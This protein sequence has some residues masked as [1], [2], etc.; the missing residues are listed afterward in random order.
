MHLHELLPTYLGCAREVIDVSPAGAGLQR[1]L[2]LPDDLPYGRY[3]LVEAA[4]RDLGPVTLIVSVVGPDPAEHSDPQTVAPL[5]RQLEV[6][7]RLILLGGWPIEAL[8][9]HRLLG[10]LVDGNCQVIDAVPLEPATAPAGV[11]CALII[12]RVEKLAPVRSHLTDTSAESGQ[13]AQATAAAADELRTLLRVV[14]ECVLAE[15]VARPSQR[16]LLELEN[17]TAERDAQVQQL[18][19]LLASS[20]SRLAVLES[21]ITFQVGQAV[22]QAVRNPVRGVVTLP[23]EMAGAWRRRKSDRV[24]PI[25]LPETQPGAG[26]HGLLTMTAPRD[27][28]VPRMLA[29]EG[30]VGYEHE[31]LACFLAAMDIAG[32]GAV[33]DIGA[34]VGVYAAVASA[35]TKREVRAFEPSPSLVAAA[36]R[37]A[38]DNNLNFTTESLALGAEN[39]VATFYLSDK[40]DSSNSLAAGFRKSSMQIEVQVE[41]LDSYVARTGMVPA[42]MKVDTE[43]TEP[44]VLTG[45]AK[46]I[47]EHRPWILCEVLAGR[48]ETRLTEVLAPFGYHWYHV[49][50]EIP[51]QETDH[52]VGDGTYRNLNWL[53]APERPDEGFWA[54]LRERS[55]ALVDCTG[56][57]GEQLRERRLRRSV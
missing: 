55:A 18:E 17:A 26:D 4:K 33:F 2:Q 16:R 49:T 5:L 46:T 24:V 39:G 43:S 32:P 14:N 12:D 29:A 44:D 6:G 48:V 7:A 3:D 22:V 54:A 45:A 36:R 9:Y 19:R 10:P 52:I 8:P 23:R 34:N 31:S 37:F 1:Y 35:L 13:D 15:F 50:D 21:S 27:L 40:T 41:T 30:L 47:A 38:L 42:V 25:A 57:R 53:F 51:Y 56:E 11:Q 28:I 20:K